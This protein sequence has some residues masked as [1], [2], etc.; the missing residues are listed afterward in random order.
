MEV[1]SL[2]EKISLNFLNN[3]DISPL[4]KSS[5]EAVS[6]YSLL[7]EYKNSHTMKKLIDRYEINMLFSSE[8]AKLLES[9]QESI[10]R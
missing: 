1:V 6:V 5:E 10:D 4:P 9:L 3:Y 2:A 7:E 8:N